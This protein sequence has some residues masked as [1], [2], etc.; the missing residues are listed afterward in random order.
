MLEQFAAGVSAGGGMT[1]SS[2]AVLG[3]TSSGSAHS[4]APLK[5]PILA[6]S[7]GV[8]R[9]TFTF[10]FAAMTTLA[11]SLSVERARLRGKCVLEAN[12]DFEPNPQNKYGKLC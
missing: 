4:G 6:G 1:S 11:R 9:A 3:I 7:L 8:E 5:Q 2:C 10:G 12:K